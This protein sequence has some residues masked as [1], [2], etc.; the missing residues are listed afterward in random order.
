MKE[1]TGNFKTETRR[2]RRVFYQPEKRKKM[3]LILASASPRRK[4][5]L[6]KIGME[7]EILPAKGEEK[8]TKTL[9]WEVVSELSQQKAKEIARQQTG[10]CIVIGADTIV[11]KDQRIM[12]KPK[13]K[14]EAFEMLRSIAGDVHQVYTGVTMIRTGEKETGVTFFEKTEV[15]LYPMSDREIDDY[16]ATGDCMDKAG[17]YGIQGDFAIHVKGIEG[18]YYN[19]M[20]LP[21]GK[22]YQ[23]LK[24]LL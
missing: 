6:G 17:A 7:F 15:F 4:E 20:G 8:I 13:T 11:A 12:G 2:N 16:I 23:E 19:V 10:E 18:D 5:L 1:I 24:Q 9:P 3:K 22:V 21:I 14:K